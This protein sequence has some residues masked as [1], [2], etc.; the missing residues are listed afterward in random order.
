MIALPSRV[1]LSVGTAM[2]LGLAG[3]GVDESFT[4]AFL[5]TYSPDGCDANCAFCPQ[6]SGSAPGSDKVSRISWPDYLLE[7]V[8]DSWPEEGAF[9]RVCI[10]SINYSG[11]VDDIAFLAR[12]VRKLTG[13]PISTAIHPVDR[14]SMRELK[15][16]GITDIGIAIDA[17]TQRLFEE[18]KGSGRGAPYRWNSHLDALDEALVVFGAGHVTTHLIVGL[19]ETE[20]EAAGFLFEMHRRGIDVGLFAFTP[21]EGTALEDTP[22]PDIGSYRRIQIVRYL[23]T[24]GAIQQ[25]QIEADENGMIRFRLSSTDLK[26]M[27]ETGTAFRVSGCRGCNR[28][29]YNERPSGPMYNYHHPLSQIELAEALTESGVGSK[30]A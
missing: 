14:E 27:L 10:Q 13:V 15:D 5:M 4:T 6:A 9:Q 1:R 26:E 29:Y 22:P 7:E 25:D 23:L 24:R 3:G 28:P 21:V 19:G 12:E 30:D 17:C 2:R 20:V 16:A 11:V 8:L 18:T